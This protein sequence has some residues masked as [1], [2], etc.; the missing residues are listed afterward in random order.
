MAFEHDSENHTGRKRGYHRQRKIRA[1]LSDKENDRKKHNHRRQSYYRY[2]INIHVCLRNPLA[3]ISQSDANESQNSL[4]LP[5]PCAH[6]NPVIAGLTRNLTIEILHFQ[7]AQAATD[8]FLCDGVNAV[9]RV[10]LN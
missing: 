9:T 6:F 2:P 4:P 3:S 8:G 10:T 7:P 5:F 1:L